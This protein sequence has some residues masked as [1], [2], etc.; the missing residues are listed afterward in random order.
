[1]LNRAKR[2]KPFFAPDKPCI[3]DRSWIVFLLLKYFAYELLSVHLVVALYK[4]NVPK[5]VV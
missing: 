3:V 5:T 2:F 1:M 4:D